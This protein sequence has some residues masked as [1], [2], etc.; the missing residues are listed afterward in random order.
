MNNVVPI[1]MPDPV[2]RIYTVGSI[3]E[4]STNLILFHFLLSCYVYDSKC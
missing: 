1:P 3:R 4:Y 2:Q